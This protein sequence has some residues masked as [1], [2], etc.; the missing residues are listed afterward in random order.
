[1]TWVSVLGLPMCQGFRA[2]MP[3]LRPVLALSRL[4]TQSGQWLCAGLLTP[5]G[6]RC[7]YNQ[8]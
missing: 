6:M 3:G 7:L 1:M 8:C 5:A 4:H 2:G